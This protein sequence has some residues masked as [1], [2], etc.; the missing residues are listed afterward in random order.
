MRGIQVCFRND[1]KRDGRSWTTEKRWKNLKST[2]TSQANSSLYWIQERN[3]SWVAMDHPG[4]DR[5]NGSKAESQTIMWW[6]FKE[7]MSETK[8]W[9]KKKKWQGMDKVVGRT[10]WC[11]R[12]PAE[13]RRN[14]HRCIAKYVRSRNESVI[15]CSK[16]IKDSHR[17]LL[18]DGDQ[19]RSS[20]KEYI[21]ELY[22]KANAPTVEETS[23]KTQQSSSNEEEMGPSIIKD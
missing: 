2:M 4:N 6:T 1:K 16:V 17:N 5:E 3:T 10:M 9:T 14:T 8:Q 22:D 21:E 12:R 15:A 7:G 18:K 13:T 23:E 20:Q 19:I 11:D